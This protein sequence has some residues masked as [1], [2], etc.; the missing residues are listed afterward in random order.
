MKIIQRIAIAELQNFFYSPIAWLIMIVFT[1][2]VAITFTDTLG[3]FSQSQEMGYTIASMSSKILGG[4][5]FDILE[6]L[7][8]YIPLL[9]MGL[10]SRELSSGSIK[11]LYSSPVKNYQI[12]LGKYLS[13]LVYGGALILILS[14]FII[15][16]F[17]TVRNFEIQTALSC[18]LGTYLLLCAYSAIG[19]FLSSLTSYQVVAAI[20]TFAM[21]SFLNIMSGVGQDIDFVRE[22]TYWLGIN[23]RA[24][25]FVSGLICSENVLYFLIVSLLFLFLTILRLKSVRE[26]GSRNVIVGKYVGIVLVA[27]L[28]GFVSSRP[29]MMF[30][31]DTTATKSNTLTPNSQEIV[32]QL[33]GGMTITTYVNLLDKR[34]N[35]YGAPGCRKRDIEHF[36]QYI[37]FKPEIK[38]KYVYYYAHADNPSLEQRYPGL[39][40]RERVEKICLVDDIDPDMFPHVSELKGVD[41]AGLAS[42]GYRMVRLIERKN[43]K[44]TYLRMFDDVTVTPKEAEISAALKRVA[45]KLPTVGYVQGHGERGFERNGDRSFRYSTVDKYFRYSL[46]NNG[47]D[48]EVLTLDREVPEQVSIL[49]L[50]DMKT[51][52]T[53]DEEK[54]LDNYIAR[55]GNLLIFGEPCRQETMNPVLERFGVRMLPGQLVTRIDNGFTP[56]F[57]VGFATPESSKL[58]WQ[59]EFLQVRNLHI[60][61]PGTSVLAYDEDKGYE[62]TPLFVSPGKGFWNELETT[63]FLD[64]KPTVNPTIGEEE[65][66][67]P[68]IVALNR[69]IAGKEQRIVISGDADCFS[70]GEVSASRLGVIPG[71][72]YYF[73]GGLFNWLSGNQAP[74]DVRRPSFPDNR[75]YLGLQG[76]EVVTICLVYV[77]PLLLLLGYL[78]LWLRRRGR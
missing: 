46:I 43:G 78:A 14:V 15:L 9:T 72:N 31:Y 10:M 47:F 73:P 35:M 37:R 55:G 70:N 67:Y 27:L 54:N 17:F 5:F 41:T 75:Y 6:Y 45:M 51:A 48:F 38:M 69:E 8:L 21:F 12:V 18:L 25:E 53:P 68:L 24:M 60:T 56:D 77:F 16:S 4:T 62:V 23:G 29:V 20:G 3:M 59:F 64:E 49:I 65:K 22:I 32:K 50:S 42:E 66:S 33:D 28:L 36:M 40:D 76:T 61:M 39:S 11:L 13:M 44:K 2:Q 7:Y 57:V 34:Y 74:V 58:A 71:N 26:G 19:L 63:D 1:I 52:L 30:F